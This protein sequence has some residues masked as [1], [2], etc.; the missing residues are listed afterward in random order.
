MDDDD[1]LW[2]SLLVCG[3]CAHLEFGKVVVLAGRLQSFPDQDAAGV[4]DRLDP[5]GRVVDHLLRRD[6]LPGVEQGVAAPTVP[7]KLRSPSSPALSGGSH[8]LAAPARP[9]RLEYQ[10]EDEKGQKQAGKVAEGQK[11]HEALSHLG[12]VLPVKER[13]QISFHSSVPLI[14]SIAGCSIR[15]CCANNQNV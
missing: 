3:I 6:V 8:R 15:L 13:A 12:F 10:V 1:L 2:F 9:G 7:I 14:D 5:A 11:D 4:F